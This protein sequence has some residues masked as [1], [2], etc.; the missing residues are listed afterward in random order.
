MRAFIVLFAWEYAASTAGGMNGAKKNIPRLHE[1]TPE[2][3]AYRNFFFC[4]LYNACAIAITN[5]G[6]NINAYPLLYTAMMKYKR[7]TAIQTH[8]S[9]E[10]VFLFLN[11]LIKSRN[12]STTTTAAIFTIQKRIAASVEVC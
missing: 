5:A 12:R 7:G 6:R 3:K 9:H 11:E 10:P 8:K 1:I 4:I 2:M